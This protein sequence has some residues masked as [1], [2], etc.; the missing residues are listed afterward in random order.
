MSI[1]SVHDAL[2][3]AA[4][5]QPL[6]MDEELIRRTLAG[7]REAFGDLALR[8][9]TRLFRHLRRLVR[10]SD[11]AEELTQEAFLRAYRG[12]PAFGART[13]FGAWLFRIA[14]NLAVDAMRRKGRVVFESSDVMGD[15]PDESAPGVAEQMDAARLRQ[16]LGAAL[17][18]LPPFMSAIVNLHYVEQMKLAEIAE[19]FQKD[20]RSIAVSL[21]RARLKLR[22]N[23]SARSG[24][25]SQNEM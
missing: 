14:T 9:E 4:P 2:K 11:D 23:L 21:H 25:A 16:Q 8:Y 6:C 7:E 19:V 12:L 5:V 24:G 10:N 20:A 1:A 3:C 15:L 18:E 13:N 22:E 17:E